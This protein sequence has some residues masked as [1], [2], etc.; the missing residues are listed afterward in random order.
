MQ[1]IL[2]RQVKY[3][4]EPVDLS[5]VV[6]DTL[7]TMAGQVI[8]QATQLWNGGAGLDVILVTGGGALLLG[9]ALQCHFRHARV[10]EEP[11]FANAL[12]YWRLAQRS[13]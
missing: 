12:G 11:V 9:P 2:D 8:A 5:E 6:E 3:Y 10:V 1:A 13:G 7:A 4:G